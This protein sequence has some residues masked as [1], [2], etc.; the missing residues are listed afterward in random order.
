[1]AKMK[2]VQICNYDVL[3]NNTHKPS[4]LYKY[5]QQIATEDLDTFNVSSKAL[6]DR[7]LAFVLARMKTVFY[8][9]IFVYDTLELSSCHR[10][11]K[12]VSFIRDYALKKGVKTVAETSSYWVLIDINSRKICRPSVLF[13]ESVLNELSS[14]EIDDRFSFPEDANTDSFLYT[15]VFS[16]IDEN[17]H[18]NN[19]R[20]PDICLDAIGGIAE[21]EFVSEIRIDYLNEA[22][23]GDKLDIKFTKVQGDGIYFKAENT[24]KGNKCFDAIIKIK[25]IKY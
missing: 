16:D 8:E 4:S 20:Y 10:K 7:G 1:M 21:D 5:F 23:I 14:F 6:L 19:T 2:D 9:P 15:V 3:F 13:S 24:V 18:M 11:T 22:K 17:L 25:N 12:G